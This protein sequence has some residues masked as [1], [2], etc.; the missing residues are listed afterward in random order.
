MREDGDQEGEGDAC[1]MDGIGDGTRCD[2]RDGR[3]MHSGHPS[4]SGGGIR[5]AG[6]KLRV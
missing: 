3:V 6:S 5:Y 1:Y 2:D 4:L